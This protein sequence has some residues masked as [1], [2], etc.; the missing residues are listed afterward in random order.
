MFTIARQH[1]AETPDVDLL[2][3]RADLWRIPFLLCIATLLLFVAIVQVDRAATRGALTLPPWVSVGGVED[4]RAIL[5]A[6][7]GAVSTVL[8]R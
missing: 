1:H 3:L 6:M 5:G 8:L 7:L 2:H 4:A